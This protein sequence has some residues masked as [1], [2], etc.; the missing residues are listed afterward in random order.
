MLDPILCLGLYESS[1]QLAG[2]DFASVRHL[3]PEC[4]EWVAKFPHFR[5]DGVQIRPLPVNSRGQ[6]QQWPVT[7]TQ[8]SRFSDHHLNA[9]PP[10]NRRFIRLPETSRVS[11]TPLDLQNV[12]RLNLPGSVLHQGKLSL[13]T[14][15]LDIL[16]RSPLVIQG[17]RIQTLPLVNTTTWLNRS[18]VSRVASRAQVGAANARSPH[19]S[20]N[21]TFL[22]TLPENLLATASHET[23]AKV[24][25]ESKRSLYS[26]GQ[27][28]SQTVKAPENRVM[29]QSPQFAVYMGSRTAKSRDGL[30]RKEAL[31]QA[32]AVIVLNEA[33]AVLETPAAVAKLDDIPAATG[34]LTKSHLT[35]NSKE[36]DNGRGT[37]LALS[38]DPASSTRTRSPPR[39]QDRKS[40]GRPV[41]FVLSGK[42]FTSTSD[43]SSSASTTP[44]FLISTKKKNN[45]KLSITWPTRLDAKISPKPHLGST[46]TSPTPS[47][48]LNTFCGR[49]TLQTGS[50]LP[51]ITINRK[52]P[53]VAL[54]QSRRSVNETPRLPSIFSTAAN[55]PDGED[56]GTNYHYSAKVS[57]HGGSNQT[58]VLEH[59]SHLRE[60]LNIEG[61]PHY[62]MNVRRNHSCVTK[63]SS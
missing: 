1:N 9:P 16:A 3:I 29:M 53:Q 5:L 33:L 7:A 45:A 22:S 58:A 27:W 37:R 17:Q 43:L 63:V 23:L 2:S 34:K 46:R 28:G 12:S 31:T 26:I 48:R 49:N 38:P 21:K 30:V 15:I 51:P 52:N 32:L 42:S 35:P 41:N 47:G 13:T 24:T 11:R 39:L 36:F 25:N 54:H 44:A 19:P 4:E 14:V 56:N 10:T 57:L 55:H 61:P 62:E 40:P 6:P 60:P 8:Q 18:R 50:T 20:N 59:L